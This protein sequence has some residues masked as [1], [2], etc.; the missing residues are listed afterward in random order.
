MNKNTFFG[1]REVCGFAY[2]QT[3]KS[4]AMKITLVILCALALFALPVITMIGSATDKEEETNIKQAYIYSNESGLAEKFSSGFDGKYENV[5]VQ[6][7]DEK[8]KDEK[9][10]ELKKGKDIDYVV[11][12]LTYDRNTESMN[13]GLEMRAV[14]GEDSKI[15]SKDADNFAEYILKNKEKLILGSIDIDAEKK[16]SLLTEKNYEL[17]SVDTNGNVE[18]AK[19]R[20]EKSEQRKLNFQ[21]SC[22]DIKIYTDKI[23]IEELFDVIMENALRYSIEEG[24]AEITAENLGNETVVSIKNR[25]EKIME[26]EL[27]RLTE[28]YY[29]IDKAASRKMGGQGFGLAIADEI[30][31]LQDGEIHIMYKEGYV[32]IT[33]HFKNERRN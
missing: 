16:D 33:L 14:Y 18:N 11:V 30:M 1:W 31:R 13:Y 20:L 6:A 22:P 9:I 32:I 8:T 26:D 10:D 21:I 25:A 28:P 17:L 29:R 19:E 7:V 2:I 12:L 23:L 27:E 4:K 5:A 24:T 3:L 15:T